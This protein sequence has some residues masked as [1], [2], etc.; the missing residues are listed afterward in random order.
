MAVDCVYGDIHIVAIA[1]FG[2]R[3]HHVGAGPPRLR[4]SLLGIQSSGPERG[5][6][7]GARLEDITVL[8][9]GKRARDN[10]DL[11]ATF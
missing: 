6:G 3:G 10:A 2:V 5:Q 1:H 7:V 11:V 9:D 4:H 8:P